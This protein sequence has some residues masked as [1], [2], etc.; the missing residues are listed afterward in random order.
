MVSVDAGAVEARFVRLATSADFQVNPSLVVLDLDCS[1][2]RSLCS[3]KKRCQ[4][5][6]L[7]GSLTRHRRQSCPSHK[8]TPELEDESTQHRLKDGTHDF[9]RAIDCRAVETGA[10]THCWWF[11]HAHLTKQSVLHSMSRVV[12]A[13]LASKGFSLQS[14]ASLLG[15]STSTAQVAIA[16]TAMADQ[17]LTGLLVVHD[18]AQGAFL[19][20]P[21]GQPQFI[22][23]YQA[24][25]WKSRFSMTPVMLFTK[26]ANQ[27]VG[28]FLP[29]PR[30]CCAGNTCDLGLC[31]P[32]APCAM[33]GQGVHT[34]AAPMDGVLDNPAWTGENERP[35]SDPFCRICQQ[36]CVSS[37]V[38]SVTVPT[39]V[40]VNP[41]LGTER[42]PPVTTALD[43]DCTSGS[44]EGSSQPQDLGSLHGS[45]SPVVA[46]PVHPVFVTEQ[47]PPLTAALESERNAGS[48]EGS[49]VAL[50]SEL[51][52][53]QPPELRSL[54]SNSSP[55]FDFE[56]SFPACLQPNSTQLNSAPSTLSQT[57]AVPVAETLLDSDSSDDLQA[58]LQ[59]LRAGCSCV[60]MFGVCVCG[61]QRRWEANVKRARRCPH[62][63][64]EGLLEDEMCKT[65]VSLEIPRSIARQA[66]E[67]HPSNLD[68]A[69]D[70]ACSSEP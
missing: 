42:T 30:F 24:L 18:P 25:K 19:F 38:M 27:A 52:P 1:S 31:G 61:F 4:G 68:A 41:N 46:V 12:D 59:I 10:R 28:H 35:C 57:S 21:G 60:A 54:P 17:Y 55:V 44:A 64:G 45:S 36:S 9:L 37:T 8:I 65:L 34:T 51:L 66:A 50:T 40:P 2:I 3:K 23:L 33:C 43:S 58:E 26:A 48:A 70:W 11:A 67:L 7:T 39:A 47:M 5:W 69:L 29:C 20:L 6:S 63:Q 56:R 15:S 32:R 62:M 22:S 49:C 13:C 53:V 16:V 14:C